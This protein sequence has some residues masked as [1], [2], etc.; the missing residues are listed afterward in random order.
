MWLR[1]T[2]KIIFSTFRIFPFIEK[3]LSNV[4]NIVLSHCDFRNYFFV[5]QISF[6]NIPNCDDMFIA[7]E[8]I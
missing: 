7:Q 6:R 5:S 8:F 2:T 4:E 1:E 3:I